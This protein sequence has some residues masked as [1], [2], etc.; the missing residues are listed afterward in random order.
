[1][2]AG[3]AELYNCLKQRRCDTGRNRGLDVFACLTRLP[4]QPG[5]GC[6]FGYWPWLA[7]RLSG[8]VGRVPRAALF[9]VSTRGAEV[10]NQIFG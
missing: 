6:D 10:M 3:V 8:W 2:M 4:D 7:A 5:W 1:M 9:P